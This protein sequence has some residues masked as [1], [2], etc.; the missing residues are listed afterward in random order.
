MDKMVRNQLSPPRLCHVLHCSKIDQF[1]QRG[2][3]SSHREGRCQ[4]SGVI[5]WVEIVCRGFVVNLWGYLSEYE[6]R[7]R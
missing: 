1:M 7:W 4:S 6:Y 3:T 5:F 2:H